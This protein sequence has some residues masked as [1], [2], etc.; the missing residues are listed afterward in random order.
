MDVL[1]APKIIIMR[2]GEMSFVVV[3]EAQIKIMMMR[4]VAAGRDVCGSLPQTVA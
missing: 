4:K 1:P 3:I 2:K